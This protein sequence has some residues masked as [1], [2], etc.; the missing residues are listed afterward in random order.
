MLRLIQVLAARHL[1]EHGRISGRM[2]AGYLNVEGPANHDIFCSDKDAVKCPG[3]LV[4][5]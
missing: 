1:N 4:H 2:H 5:P 3:C